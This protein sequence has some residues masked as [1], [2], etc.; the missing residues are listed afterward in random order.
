MQQHFCMKWFSI[1]IT[2]CRWK[3][4]SWHFMYF[5]LRFIVIEGVPKLV[6]QKS[7]PVNSELEEIIWSGNFSKVAPRPQNFFPPPPPPPDT[8]P[9]VQSCLD[10]LP[11]I[12]ESYTV[13][14]RV[15][16]CLWF[17]V[18]QIS[19]AHFR[20]KKVLDH[21]SQ[22][23]IRK[24]YYFN[25]ARITEAVAT[26]DAD[27]FHRIWDEIAYRWDIY[28]VTRGNQIEHLWISVDKREIYA[29]FC[30]YVSQYC[31]FSTFC[32]ITT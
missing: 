26:I 13:A 7:A 21:V 22:I 12:M 2:P 1:E 3:A 10:V 31:M 19:I 23:I 32:V 15:Q 16:C 17:V 11:I 6:I 24:N 27:M 18:A 30:D 14:E 28:R 8:I 4:W 9:I 5:P 29:V 20:S 25:V